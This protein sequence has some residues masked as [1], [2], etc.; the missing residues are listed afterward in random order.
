LSV[1]VSSVQVSSVQ[2]MGNR[3]K[4][5]GRG[6]VK[7]SMKYKISLVVFSLVVALSLLA[8]QRFHLEP[9]A[10][11]PGA[12]GVAEVGHDGN[13]NTTLNIHVGRLARPGQ[14]SPARVTYVAWAEAPGRPAENL[15]IVTVGNDQKGDLN[16]LTTLKDFRLVITAEDSP[17]VTIPTGPIVLRAMIH[18]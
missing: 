9:T 5:S 6:L 16:A 10:M 14:L 18:Q 1:L 15:G 3:R 12:T 4:Q 2:V 11:V 7:V 8:A 17:Q 13:G